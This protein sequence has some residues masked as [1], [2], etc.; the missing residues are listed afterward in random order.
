MKD[1][2]EYCKGDESFNFVF[3]LTNISM[4]SELRK[5]YPVL[6][7]IICSL[8]TKN[9]MLPKEIGSF[10]SKIIQ[11]S[12][13]FFEVMPKH[14][15]DNFI[16]YRGE[17]LMTEVFPNFPIRF[18]KPLYSL[19]SA[20]QDRI[21]WKNLCHKTWKK[22]QALTPGIFLVVCACKNKSV[23][24]FSMM[25]KSESPS[26]IF[27][28]VTTRFESDYRPDWAYDASCKAKEFGLQSCKMSENI[29]QSNLFNQV[30][31]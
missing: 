10:I 21:A 12:L 2:N 27:D 30:L 22:P 15:S 1:L 18:Q 23:Y 25:V 6:T 11:H 29:P 24:G 26:Y 5:S 9:G 3:G 31:P 20:I 19:K 4:Q 28:I 14:D 16:P 17:E 7:N 8:T 13:N